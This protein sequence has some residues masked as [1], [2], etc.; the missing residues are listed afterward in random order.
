MRKIKESVSL[1]VVIGSGISLDNF[2][3][4]CEEADGLIIGEK[5]FKEGG[6]IGGPSK[7]EAYETLVKE[8]KRM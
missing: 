6:I 7:K 2:R 4:Y 3:S 5:D 8:C 1:P